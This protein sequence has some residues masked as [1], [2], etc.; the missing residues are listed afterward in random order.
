MLP[1]YFFHVRDSHNMP[2]EVG[3]ELRYEQTAKNQAV[4][5]AGEMLKELD[6]DFWTSSMWKLDVV[7]EADGEVCQLVVS[8]RSRR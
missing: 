3:T 1:R 6:G 2:E 8:S 5:L 7:D 4:V